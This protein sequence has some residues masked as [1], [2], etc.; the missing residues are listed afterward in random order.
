MICDIG[1]RTP[2]STGGAGM[3]TKLAARND[4]MVDTE[5]T[6][7]EPESREGSGAPVDSAWPRA[8]LIAD[9]ET[10][11]RDN[12]A[13]RFSEEGRLV[14][15]ASDFASATALIG[16]KQPGL[17][18]LEIRL[19]EG[20]GRGLDLMDQINQL[21]R[22]PRVVILTAYGS[23]SSPIRAAPSGGG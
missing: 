10:S 14:E 5:S 7:G 1:P 11:F 2:S 13:R 6:I 16:R 19:R 17:G 12:L 9:P 21:P 3:N 20:A 4:W 22:R 18:G 15:V 23:S 8:V